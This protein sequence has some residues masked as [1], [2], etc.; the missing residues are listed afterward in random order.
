ML[1]GVGSSNPPLPASESS[2][3]R[4]ARPSRNSLVIWALELGTETP[5]PD[6]WHILR[7]ATRPVQFVPGFLPSFRGSLQ[8]TAKLGQPSTG[9]DNF[10][11]L[12]VSGEFGVTMLMQKSLARAS[13]SAP[14]PTDL[15]PGSLH[16]VNKYS[17]RPFCRRNVCFRKCSSNH[18]AVSP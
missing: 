15:V 13:R 7:Y 4:P 9:V 5:M 12:S 3:C 10:D 1:K 17:L 8:I 2:S 6:P 14:P 11:F 18:R 16:P